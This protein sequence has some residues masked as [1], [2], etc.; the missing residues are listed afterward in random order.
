[1]APPVG[2]RR[3]PSM[4]ESA[5]IQLVNI[6]RSQ[7]QAD[8]LASIGAK[9]V[10]NASAASFGADLTTAVAAT[11]ATLAFDATGG[12]KL[13]SEILAAMERA[14]NLRSAEYSR[15][16]SGT[17]KQVYIYG[18]LERSPTMLDRNFGMAWGVSGWLL[19]PFLQRIGPAAVDRMRQRVAAEIK[20]TFA[21]H[22][23][24]EVSLD[25][26]LTLEAIGKYSQQATGVKFLI[27]PNK[28]M[29]RAKM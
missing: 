15:Y 25:E 28:K 20:S 7:Q 23:T 11:G 3:R 16:G 18:G 1:M 24:A 12:G 6:V 2:M 26:A 5:G 14:V 29:Q 8:L 21:S 10:C 22:Y 17:H 27:N 9:H 19:T 4:P 13:A